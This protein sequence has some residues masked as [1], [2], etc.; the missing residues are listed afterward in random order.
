MDLTVGP[1]QTKAGKGGHTD[2]KHPLIGNNRKKLGASGMH[3][4]PRR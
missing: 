2:H 1:Y 4:Y 3:K